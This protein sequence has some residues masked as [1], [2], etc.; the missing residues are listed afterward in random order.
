MLL[1]GLCSILQVG[2]LPGVLVLM[3]A[4]LACGLLRTLVLSF[5]LSLVINHFLVV[6]LV[7]AGQFRPPVMWTIFAVEM[8]ILLWTVQGHLLRPVGDLCGWR[9]HWANLMGARLPR[10]TADRQ[11]ALRLTILAAVWFLILAYAAVELWR[12]GSIFVAWDAV[13]WWNHWG[14]QWAQGQFPHGTWGYPQLLSTNYAVTYV[15]LD[16]TSLWFFAKSIAFLFCLML[17]LGIIEL[18]YRTGEFGYVLGCALTYW[19]LWAFIRFRD[20]SCGYADVPLTFFAFVS[21]SMLIVA[22]RAE[23]PREKLKHVILGAT[24]AAGAA[25]TKQVGLWV[26]GLYPLLVWMIVYRPR[27]L[28]EGWSVFLPSLGVTLAATVVVLSLAGPWY[29]YALLHDSSGNEP[30][31][32]TTQLVEPAAPAESLIA[33]FG[34][35][36]CQAMYNVS[37]PLAIIA[38]LGVLHALRHPVHRWFVMLVAMPWFV[39]WT[40]GF[41][42]DARNLALV[43]PFAGMAMGF[44]AVQFSPMASRPELR[45]LRR[46]WK[47]PAW[48]P[49]LRLA[50]VLGLGLAVSV[51]LNFVITPEMLAARQQALQRCVGMPDFNEQLYR[52]IEDNNH[53]IRGPILSDYAVLPWLPE[54]ADHYR[55]RRAS[56]LASFRQALEDPSVEF[57]ILNSRQ[58]KAVQVYLDACV[59]RGA[60]RVEI[61]EQFVFMLYRKVRPD[62]PPSLSGRPNYDRARNRR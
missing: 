54:F 58:P 41:D 28:R 39:I 35:A 32:M 31:P 18:Y 9:Q 42:Y 5:A 34:T 14:I 47:Q 38:V 51:L 2:F 10:A 57:A 12:I 37:F 1:Q 13:V 29:A 19:L 55:P 59:R 46:E 27:R 45:L 56:D 21:A 4:R 15:F 62:T 20:L 49:R 17:L 30:P 33:R 53:P 11:M 43:A 7:W 60:L 25:L 61:P 44:A 36:T 48:L 52:Y 24:L 26:A 3:Y 23:H 16:D 22:R 8:A 40:L 6:G 50:Y